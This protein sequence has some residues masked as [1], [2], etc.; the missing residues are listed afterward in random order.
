MALAGGALIRPHGRWRE[1]PVL[2]AVFTGMVC[3]AYLGAMI[4]GDNGRNG[5]DDAAAVGLVFL[6]PAAAACTVGLA[7]LGR[8]VARAAI[9][10]ARLFG[11]RAGAG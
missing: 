1:V 7:S 6:G 8:L 11:E 5:N 2:A 9:A 10:V 3:V 4:A